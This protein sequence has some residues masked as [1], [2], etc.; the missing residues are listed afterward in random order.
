MVFNNMETKVKKLLHVSNLHAMAQ[1]IGAI[2]QKITKILPL[3]T[4]RTTVNNHPH[5]ISKA[6]KNQMLKVE[7][8]KAQAIAEAYRKRMQLL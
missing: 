6:S 5:T 3:K 2:S 7:L 8:K 4:S 1:N